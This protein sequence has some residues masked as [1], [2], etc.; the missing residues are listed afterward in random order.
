MTW[1][2]TAAAL[3]AF[4]VWTFDDPGALADEPVG[5]IAGNESGSF[6]ASPLSWVTTLSAPTRFKALKF[7]AIT[8]STYTLFIDGVQYGSPIVVAV[9]GDQTFTFDVTLAAGARTWEIRTTSTIKVFYN[10]TPGTLPWTVGFWLAFGTPYYVPVEYTIE[11]MA[12]H[13][14]AHVGPAGTYVSPYAVGQSHRFPG[15]GSSSV[16]F[17]NAGRGYSTYTTAQASS[18]SFTVERLFRLVASPA[19]T[20]RGLIQLGNTESNAMVRLS[21]LALLS[22]KINGNLGGKNFI[23]TGT[24]LTPGNNYHLVVVGDSTSIRL[25]VNGAL[26][27][28]FPGAIGSVTSGVLKMPWSYDNTRVADIYDFG[29]ALYRS[30]LTTPEVE[31]LYAAAVAIPPGSMKVWDGS[32]WV[33]K[34]ARVWNGSAWVIKPVKRWTGSAW[35]PTP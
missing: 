6:Y 13:P 11:R 35:V 30:A 15:V 7:R 8:P 10:S 23:Q 27:Q 32:S 31:S 34:P 21:D 24:A 18:T 4:G 20:A 25:Y 17:T 28:T 33:K 29:A 1:A 2:T 16:E 26:I 14:V 19:N 22:G 3:G 9:A 12:Y 5:T